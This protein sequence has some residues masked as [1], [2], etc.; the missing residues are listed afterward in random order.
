MSPSKPARC[1]I[2]VVNNWQDKEDECQKLHDALDD[3]TI[4]RYAIVGK[5]VG[6][7]GTPHFQCY[8]AFV[9]PK[10]LSAVRKICSCHWEIAKGNEESNFKYIAENPEKPDPD[11]VEYGAR[12]TPGKR[13]DLEAAIA[14]IKSGVGMS[15]LAAD[16]SQAYVKFHRG[17]HALALQLNQKY[18]HTTVRGIW[19]WGP[20]GSGK[21]H[22]ARYIAGEHL[23][24]KA[25]NK[26]WCGYSGEHVV[27]LDDLDTP[28]LGHYLKRWADK[29]ACTGETK[30]GTIHLQHR[31][32]IVTSNYPPSHFWPDDTVMQEAVTRRFDVIE[33]K[34]RNT[35]VDYLQY[36]P[37]A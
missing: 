3:P 28:T 2:A 5:E 14:D 4:T 17:L 26:W 1:W 7:Q 29:Y 36:E 19:L 33:K 31:L 37:S 22:T 21:S 16:H 9:K 6:V 18:E 11:Y 32:F 24:D 8:V 25:Q 10:R 23:F 34:D 15:K 20:P 35:I 30:G 27:L 13:S 12:A